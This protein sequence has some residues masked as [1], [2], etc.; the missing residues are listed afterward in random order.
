MLLV[1]YGVLHATSDWPRAEFQGWILV[2]IA[3]GSAIPLFL[4]IIQ[5]LASVGGTI[6][7]P[8]GVKLSFAAASTRAAEAVSTSTL[9]ENLDMAAGE[10]QHHTGIRNILSALREARRTD[11]TIVDL[12]EGNTWWESRLFILIAAAARRRRPS[13]IAFVATVNQRPRTFIGWGDPQA[14]LEQ[15]VTLEPGYLTAHRFAEAATARWELG[16]PIPGTDQSVEL[17]WTV[18]CGEE[19]ARERLPQPTSGPADCTFAF[20]LYLQ[21]AC[22]MNV[23]V[24]EPRRPV[25]RASLEELL[26]RY[27]SGTL[28][29]TMPATRSG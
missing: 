2:A 12:R 17:P 14:L 8:G 11:V 9:T 24:V 16:M 20:E 7:G 1:V 19:K 21:Q 3:I 28:S 25:G 4:L 6:E 15:H 10:A 29:L 13:A 23:S 27:L 26:I 5:A 22:E 18:D